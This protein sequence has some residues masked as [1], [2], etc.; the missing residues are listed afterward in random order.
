M[1]FEQEFD[2]QVAN[3]IVRNYPQR[4]GVQKRKFMGYIRKLKK[5]LKKI[6][7]SEKQS[8]THIPFILVV[9][10]EMVSAEVAMPLIEID[11]V[12]GIVDMNPCKS[13]DFSVIREVSIPY[14]RVVYLAVDIDTG[15]DTQNMSPDMARRMLLKQHRSPLT[16]EEGVSL[17]M[18][19]PHI[20]TDRKKYNWFY[21][22]ASRRNDQRVPAIWMSFGKPRLGWCWNGNP[23]S[24]L[25]SA[26]CLYRL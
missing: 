4:I 8:D 16:I 25:G 15:R 12:K 24:W 11:G 21:L 9:K 20:L 1:E 14:C 17:L 6:T 3:M 10:N 13:T 2:R 5:K 19:F 23:H 7:V 22:S 18:H 26:S